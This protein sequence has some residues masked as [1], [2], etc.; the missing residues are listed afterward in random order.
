MANKDVEKNTESLFASLAT[1]REKERR[2][3]LGL[4]ILGKK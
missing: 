4:A 1:I 3:K 2:N